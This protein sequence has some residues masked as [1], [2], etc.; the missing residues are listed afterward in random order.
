MYGIWLDGSSNNTISGN[1]ITANIYQGIRLVY[2]SSSNTISENNITNNDYGI[3]LYW[4]SNYN[5]I[6]HNNF[7]DN[8]GQVYLYLSSN[9]L[10]DDGYPSGGNYWSDHVT[11]DDCCGINQDEF[12]SDGIVDE[13]YLIDGYNR[14]NCP[15]MAPINFFNAGTWNE[16]TYY[17][18][19][20]SNSTVSDFYF[21][22]DEGAFIRIDVTEDVGT[23]GFCRVTIPKL[24]LWVEDGWVVL[25]GNEPV[26][27]TIVTDDN[28]TYLY[29]TYNHSTKTVEILGTNVVPEFPTWT[30]ILLLLIVFTI[31]IAIIKRRLLKKPFH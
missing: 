19:T 30:S 12:G 17:V 16:V 5:I 25:V 18:N 24:L 26:E 31:A 23:T 2:G 22:P 14:D 15:L 9:N 3:W 10:W 20:V 13:P 4:A 21:D 1:N 28:Y 29:F 8:A 6:R 27:Y 7:V 11:V